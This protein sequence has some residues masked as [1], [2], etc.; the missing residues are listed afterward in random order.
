MGCQW[1][2]VFIGNITADWKSSK[3]WIQIFRN[4]LLA[5]IKW[6]QI[7]WMYWTTLDLAAGKLY[8]SN[9][10]SILEVFFFFLE[11]NLN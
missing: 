10:Q 8:S 3:K 6:L 4:I 2:F 7:K 1:A 11:R 9:N 5:Q